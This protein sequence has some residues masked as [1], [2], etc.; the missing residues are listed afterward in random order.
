MEWWISVFGVLRQT[1]ERVAWLALF[2]SC[3]IYTLIHRIFS[4]AF[5]VS[6]NI[7]RTYFMSG[8]G[9]WE[10]KDERHMLPVVSIFKIRLTSQTIENMEWSLVCR[11]TTDRS[12]C[13]ISVVG[14]R[15]FLKGLSVGNA[16]G[17]SIIVCYRVVTSNLIR[18]LSISSS[19]CIHFCEGV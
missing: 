18:F 4:F 12:S 6:Q 7:S 8:T 15:G 1:C 14:K 2:L 16:W 17:D 13:D 9:K 11:S 3:T 19:K 10:F 5:F